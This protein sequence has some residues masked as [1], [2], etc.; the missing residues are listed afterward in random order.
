MTTVAIPAL[1]E[2]EALA[3]LRR[4]PDGRITANN[5]ELG[6]AWNWH[7]QRV[8]RW[9]K[10]W[11]KAGFVRRM[12]KVVVVTPPTVTKDVTDTVTCP[13]VVPASTTIVASPVNRTSINVA[14]CLTA[15]TLTCVSGWFSILG[16]TTI[17]AAA[18]WP[19]VVMG[20]TLEVGKLVTAAWL[21]RHWRSTGWPLK[22]TLTGM[23]V[24]LVGIT[25]TG[26]F[27]FLSKAHLD[28]QVGISVAVV[29]RMAI[30]DGQIVV[31]AQ[32]I[33]DLDRR[34]SQIDTAIEA[35]VSRGRSN[36]AMALA[37]QERKTRTEL[38][39]NRQTEAQTLASLQVRKAAIDG[40]RK[41]LEAEVGPVRYLAQFI[42]GD[43]ADL[44]RSVRLLVLVLAAVFDPLAVLLM[45]AAN[46]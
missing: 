25:S 37:S 16:L 39:T 36:S 1:S 42:G 43:D 23:V 10:S 32:A 17:F 44:D 8:G 33:A 5:A 41:R 27:G 4:Q 9:L 46:R 20:G 3:W 19:V 15:V 21:S 7:R 6:R 38:A 14:A 31:Q 12:G 2:E 45:V 22:Y 29:D 28:Y 34:I 35:S 13:V 26:V 11:E 18:F 30:I 24:V 40:E